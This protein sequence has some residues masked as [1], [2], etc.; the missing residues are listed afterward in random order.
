[1]T[2]QCLTS[3]WNQLGIMV[4]HKVQIEAINSRRR[5]RHHSTLGGHKINGQLKQINSLPS[6]KNLFARFFRIYTFKRP[7]PYILEIIY[8]V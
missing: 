1:M 2:E 4:A 6:V 3:M 8:V 5:H 7:C